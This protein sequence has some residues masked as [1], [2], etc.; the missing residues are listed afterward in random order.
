MAASVREVDGE[1]GSRYSRGNS[2]ETH[3][4]DLDLR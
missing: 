1:L 4:E 2:L 3:E